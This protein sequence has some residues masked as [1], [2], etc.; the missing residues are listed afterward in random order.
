[1]TECERIA[2]Q[3]RRAMD[4]GAWHGPA[5]RE[6][7][8]EMPA[9]TAAAKPIPGGHSIWEI[10]LHVAAWTSAVR[11]RLHG[12]QADLPPEEDWPAIHETGPEAW[13]AA[14]GK[15]EDEHRRLLHDLE[16]LDVGRLDEPIVPG[17]SSVYMHLQGLAQHHTYHAGQI[18]LL[19]KAAGQS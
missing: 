1:M 10:V 18:A 8:K 9:S 17:K 3:L 5:V 11:R 4:G 14:L 15:L 12:E 19:R 2:D 6:L 13:A 7:L 16:Q